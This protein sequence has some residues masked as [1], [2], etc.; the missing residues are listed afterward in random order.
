[1]I[2]YFSRLKQFF[3]VNFFSKEDIIFISEPANW[4]IKEICEEMIKHL[5]RASSLKGS[6][7]FSP[8]FLRNKILHFA[9]VNSL[10]VSGKIRYFHHSNRTVLSWYHVLDGDSR[11]NCIPEINKRIDLVHTS[12]T[13]TRDILLS[14]GLDPK[15]CVLIP[16]GIDLDLFKVFSDQQKRET[17][18]NLGIPD[19]KIIIGSFQKDGNGWGEGTE[20]KWEKGPDV[21]CDVVGAL[22]QKFNIHVVLTGPARGYV[23]KRLDLAGI[24]YTH[25][26]LGKYADIVSY[27]NVLDVYLITSRIEGG[28]KSV[29]ESWACGVPLI[30]TSV[31]MAKDL[32]KDGENGFL[33]QVG[34]VAG[35]VQKFFCLYS[36]KEKSKLFR[37][38]SAVEVKKYDWGIIVH[39]FL[40]L[41]YAKLK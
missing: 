3:S 31:G 10:I 33:T 34:D 15:K 9:S 16:E 5:A 38:R 30:S 24:S 40:D 8:L 12:C 7:S 17:K 6:L 39:N 14:H 4:V 36:D 22:S 18:K 32:I 20:P 41:I 37:E 19:N 2:S 27:Y 13:A 26:F 23:K 29:L 21:F 25:N 28:P 1:M 11:L 35:L